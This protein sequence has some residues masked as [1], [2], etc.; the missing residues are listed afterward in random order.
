MEN[1]NENWKIIPQ[2]CFENIGE[3]FLIFNMNLDS[4][5]SLENELTKTIPAF[6]KELLKTWR[7][8]GDKSP[9]H[10]REIRKQII[11]G[12]KYIKYKGKCLVRIDWIK[13]GIIFI[14]DILDEFGRISEY[15]IIAKLRDKQN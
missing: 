4:F 7:R 5:T 15:K 11:W 2:K 12:N 3:N 9:Q 10:F 13:S 8:R 6:Y 1:S 14:N